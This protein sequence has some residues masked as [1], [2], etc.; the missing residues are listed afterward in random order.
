MLRH[1][2]IAAAQKITIIVGLILSCA[3]CQTT[4]STVESGG[5]EGK[6][7]AVVVGDRQAMVKN[8]ELKNVRNSV[9]TLKESLKKNPRNLKNLVALS[10]H[11]LALGELRG[12]ESFAKRALQIDF[13]A[14]QPKVVLAQTAFLRGHDVTAEAIV[15]S[16]MTNKQFQSSELLNLAGC[17]ALKKNNRDRALEYFE[18]A[19]AK[20]SENVAALMN[21]GVLHLRIGTPSEAEAYLKDALKRLPDNPDIRMHL[22][23]A[24]AMLGDFDSAKREYETIPKMYRKK[25]I[26]LFNMAILKKREGNLEGALA[27]LKKYL[28]ENN[29]HQI[30]EEIVSGLIA[31]LNHRINKENDYDEGSNNSLARSRPSQLGNEALSSGYIVNGSIGTFQ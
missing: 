7:F 31:D 4:K 25:P 20:D 5:K 15:D 8:N 27:D 18:N 30:Q 26:Y 12:A 29:T 21:L 19:I 22:G 13:R 24:Y 28:K 16:M 9:Q 2:N 23:V 11:L 6:E 14:H 17:I 3:S 10:E 1:K